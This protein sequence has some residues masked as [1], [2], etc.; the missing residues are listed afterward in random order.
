MKFESTVGGSSAQTR[1]APDAEGTAILDPRASSCETKGPPIPTKAMAGV[2]SA[3]AG[4][5]SR[6]GHFAMRPRGTSTRALPSLLTASALALVVAMVGCSDAASEEAASAEAPVSEGV[7]S[8]AVITLTNACTAKALDVSGASRESGARVIQWTKNGGLNQQWKLAATD[9]GYYKLIAQHS[10]MALGVAGGASSNGAAAEQSTDANA[11]SQQW[12]FTALGDGRYKLAPRHAANKVLD[13][14]SNS[15]KVQIWDDTGGC[16]QAWDVAT[17]SAAASPTGAVPS[18]SSGVQALRA[19]DFIDTTGV[20]AHFERLQDGSSIWSSKREGLRTKLLESG[21]PHIRTSHHGNMSSDGAYVKYLKSLDGVKIDLQTDWNYDLQEL[22][23][24]A[25]ALGSQ[26]VTIESR[27]EPDLRWVDGSPEKLRKLQKDLF[28]L[29]NTN[30]SLKNVKLLGPSVLGL[31]AAKQV[32]DMSAHVDFLNPHMYTGTS[33]PESIF[34]DGGTD[35]SGYGSFKAAKA[36][37]SIMGGDK[38]MMVTET[39]EH[40]YYQQVSGHLGTTEK[41]AGRVTPRI[42]LELARRGACRAFIY[43][44]VDEP[45]EGVEGHFGLLRGDLSEK[46]AFRAVKNMIALL[47]DGATAGRTFTPGKLNYGLS[48]NTN[49]VSHMLFQKADGTFY[50]ALWLGKR[51]WDWKNRVEVAVTNQTVTLSTSRSS[52]AKL[53]TLDD[54]G[55]M[56]AGAATTISGGKIDISVSDRVTFV[57][58]QQ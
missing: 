44:L 42:F 8:G 48:G 40:N 54:D 15:E 35:G 12:K 18:D 47:K 57:E 5:L 9:S 33:N 28:D 24:V 36:M 4:V 43:E 56:K 19:A 46:P 21:I 11:A 2:R 16:A 58:L 38:C 17:I 1:L 25:T 22:P 53:H 13:S 27:N 51:A 31:D 14:R 23:A 50:V 52:V 55:V 10:K 30:A 7:Q 39:G 45:F 37:H 6:T 32:G 26:L 20:N 41:I 3:S 29:R 49:S 34:A